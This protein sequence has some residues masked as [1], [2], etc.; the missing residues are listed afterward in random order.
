M[1]H[2]LA[3]RGVLKDAE[4]TIDRFITP[5]DSRWVTDRLLIK[6]SIVLTAKQVID[7]VKIFRK[8]TGITKENF[9]GRKNAGNRY[10]T[11]DLQ[12]LIQKYFPRSFALAIAKGW[13][14][15]SHHC[16]KIYCNTAYFLYKNQIEKL[17][18][19]NVD[20]SIFISAVLGHGSNSLPTYLSYANVDI[21]F[22]FTE[23]EFTL[24]PDHQ[25]RLLKG[26][27]EF[28]KKEFAELK[29][30][31]RTQ[32]TVAK[33]ETQSG[34]VGIKDR[35]GVVQHFVKHSKRAWTST[36]DRDKTILGFINQLIDKNVE[37]TPTAVTSMAIG[38]GS[39]NDYRNNKPV[40]SKKA[41]LNRGKT[42]PEQ[43]VPIKALREKTIATA[44][45]PVG[46]RVI[47]ITNPKSSDNA[48]KQQLKR[49]YDTFGEDNVIETAED[50]KGTM[51]K[52]QKVTTNKGTVLIRDICV[53]DR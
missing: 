51:L 6:M 20:R 37:V 3:Q 35:D 27:I 44:T 17:T 9:P 29:E 7:G 1:S 11:R 40:E 36:E 13:S 22:G 28:L 32:N 31:L 45:L 41:K 53:D 14:I 26:E 12:P 2:L 34:Y 39:Y 25:I 33:V 30:L 50:C 48:K 38:G 24:P 5:E 46:S 52:K 49:A 23:Q 4:S 16:R 18:G 15:S 43:E 19:D 21:K 47:A 8:W 42:K 10:G